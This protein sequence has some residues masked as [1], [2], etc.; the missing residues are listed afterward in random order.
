MTGGTASFLSAVL[1]VERTQWHLNWSHRYGMESER[2]ERALARG[3]R[4]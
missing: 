2:V 3:F 4:V 1:G